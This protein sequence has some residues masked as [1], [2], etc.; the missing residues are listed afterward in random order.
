MKDMK[1]MEKDI[2]SNSYDVELIP[3]DKA[4]DNSLELLRKRKEGEIVGA[5]CRWDKVNSV[6]G[7]SW[8]K[9]CQYVIGGQPGT[10]KTVL[11]DLLTYD[12]TDKYLNKHDILVVFW[13]FEMP[14][15]RQILRI[16]SS[17]IDSTVNQMMSADEPLQD[18]LFELIKREAEEL[19]G[20]NVVFVDVPTSPKSILKKIEQLYYENPDTHIINIL[21]HSL[22]ARKEKESDTNKEL[23]GELSKTFMFAKKKYKCT[24][25]IFSQVKRDVDGPDRKKE[26]FIPRI[27]DLV[28]CSEMEHDADVIIFLHNFSK[29]NID[30]FEG[31]STKNMILMNVAKNRDGRIGGVL[32]K[33]NLKYNTLMEYD[34]AAIVDDDGNINLKG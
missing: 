9:S 4:I 29:H 19:K 27:T 8:Q 6:L 30:Q 14:S 5:K 12:F 24:N 15:E 22:L 20:R 33:E 23:I 26:L 13:N 11:A 16:L 7:G 21:D 34:T 10:G 28:W 25:I 3:F 32:M 17:R 18:G 2:T 31:R 1:M